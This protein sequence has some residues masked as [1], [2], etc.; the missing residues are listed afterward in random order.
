MGWQGGGGE[1]AG[2]SP[3]RNFLGK[4]LLDDVAVQEG[5]L[6]VGER[7]LKTRYP[8][9]LETNGKA[10]LKTREEIITEDRRRVLA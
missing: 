5:G 6:H 2:D 7:S 9:G 1:G 4:I 8:G 10:V 3:K